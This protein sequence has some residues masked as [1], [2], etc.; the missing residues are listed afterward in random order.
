M[1]RLPDF[2]GLAIFAKV[3]ELRSFAAR[4]Q[5]AQ[6]FQ[7]HR[8]E[9]RQPGSRRGWARG[10]STAPRGGWRSPTPDGSS[11]IAPRASS[12]RARQP[13]TRPGA[14][15]DAARAGAPRR[16]HVLRGAHVAP[17]L[18]EFLAVYPDV[19]VDL[20]LSDEMVDLIGDGLRRRLAHRGAAGF[21]LAGEAAPRC[22]SQPRRRSVLSRAS[23]A[24]VPSARPHASCLPLLCLSSHARRL[25]VRQ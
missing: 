20:H 1:A 22:H 10:C 14:S 4:R 25:A 18:P 17:L 15:G 5:G 13:R 23:R 3:A 6:A 24:P 19:S 7:S 2:E 9:S 16:A 21:L 8:L 12:P 11:P